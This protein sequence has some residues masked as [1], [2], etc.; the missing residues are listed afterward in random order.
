MNEMEILKALAHLKGDACKR[1]NNRDAYAVFDSEG[2]RLIEWQ[3][4]EKLAWT[5]YSAVTK[6]LYSRDSLIPLIETE[7][8]E[9]R[10]EHTFIVELAREISPE[11]DYRVTPLELLIASPYQL[12][13]AILK[14]TGRWKYE[15]K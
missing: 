14:T 5:Q 7:I 15:P 10:E 9:K 13:V 8:F 1:A 4:D 6:L 2:Q 12:K 3:R 11:K